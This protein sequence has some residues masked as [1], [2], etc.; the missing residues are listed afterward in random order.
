MKGGNSDNNGSDLDKGNILKPTFD[1][2]MAEGRKAF[3]A[4]HANLEELFLSYCEV[5]W[6]GTVLKDTIPII[7]NKPEVI[8]EV[9]PNPSPSLNDVQVMINSV[10]ERQA[11]STDELLRRLIEEWDGKK[12]D[13]TSTNPSSSTCTVSFTQTNP[14]TSGPSLGGTSMSNPS[15]QSMNHFHSRTTIEG[16]AP[17]LGMPHQATTSMYG[18]GYTHTAPSLTI[19]NLSLTPYTSGL[20]GWVYP[21]PNDNFQAPYTTVA[22]TDPILLPRRSLGFLPN[23]AYQLPPCFNA[24]G[25]LETGGFGYETSL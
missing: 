5:T 15:T 3:E 1:T 10:L 8:P 2:L 13:A 7:F 12:L 16:S 21:N 25:Q 6:Q 20:N 19:P 18:Q 14:H 17:N 9:R 24:Y 11:K 4:Y 22:Y 23:H